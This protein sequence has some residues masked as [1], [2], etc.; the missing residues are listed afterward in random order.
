[1]I[2]TARLRTNA[3]INLFLR[4]IGRRPDGYHEIE[5]I[6]HTIGLADSITIGPATNGD[7]DIAWRPNPAR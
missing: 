3:K 7:V 6:F 5:T 4:V 1:M 2:R